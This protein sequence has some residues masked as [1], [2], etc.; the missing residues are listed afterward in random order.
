MN[1]FVTNTN[2]EDIVSIFR[3]YMNDKFNVKIPEEDQSLSSIAQQQLHIVAANYNGKDTLHELN[4]QVLG[5]LR[6]FYVDKLQ[7]SKQSIRDSEIFTNRRVVFN[8]NMPTDT[9]MMRINSNDMVKRMEL[10]NSQRLSDFSKPIPPDLE[11]SI[12]ETAE[13]SDNFLAKV[14]EF[15]KER[16]KISDVK[17]VQLPAKMRSSPLIDATS[18]STFY[19]NEIN[20]CNQKLL[21]IKNNTNVSPGQYN[22]KLVKVTF[23]NLYYDLLLT[24]SYANDTYILKKIDNVQ[25]DEKMIVLYEPIIKS[26]AILNI[27]SE[28]NQIEFD[29]A[30][31][32][33]FDIVV[34]RN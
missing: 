10:L 33:N 28:K 29:N 12:K 4:L 27:T 14:R 30:N 24:L 18:N 15:E 3:Q 16:S 11:P 2:L 5:G 26:D 23:N 1:K 25:Q 22:I 7:R 34:S 8:N 19:I 17:N 6:R 20:D 13:T 21:L 31:I 32:E 9:S